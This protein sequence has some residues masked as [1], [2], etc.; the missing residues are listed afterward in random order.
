MCRVALRAEWVG[1][2][3]EKRTAVKSVVSRVSNKFNVSIAEIDN[4]DMHKDIAIGFACVTNEARHA[5]SVIQ[6][7]LAFIER[8]TDAVVVD[9]EIEIL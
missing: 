9:T 2:L 8:N 4:Q 1:S 6:N 5:Q 3:K 7:V